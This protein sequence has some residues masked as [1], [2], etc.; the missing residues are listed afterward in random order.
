M[1]TLTPETHTYKT[2]IFESKRATL[3][4]YVLRSHNKFQP[5]SQNGILTIEYTILEQGI[6]A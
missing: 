4:H 1:Y 2:C 5:T 3:P 6:I